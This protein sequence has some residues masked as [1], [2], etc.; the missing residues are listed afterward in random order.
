[1]G[2]PPAWGSGEGLAIP[3]HKNLTCYEMLYMALDLA[4]GVQELGCEKNIFGPKNEE[5]TETSEKCTMR[6]FMICVLHEI[7]G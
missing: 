4:E 6:V 7:F 5:A 2:G 3:H 1:M